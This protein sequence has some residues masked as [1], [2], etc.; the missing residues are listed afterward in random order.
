MDGRGRWARSLALGAREGEVECASAAA[1]V[2][3]WWSGLLLGVRDKTRAG[4]ALLGPAMVVG[5]CWGLLTAA[6]RV[7]GRRE[8]S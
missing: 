7:G 8:T 5:C 4:A 3:H 2:P 1:W 6:E